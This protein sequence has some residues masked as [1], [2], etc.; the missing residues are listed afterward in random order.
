MLLILGSSS[1]GYEGTPQQP[2]DVSTR[3]GDE[4]QGVTGQQGIPGS[5]RGT[6]QPPRWT[7]QPVLGSQ[8]TTKSC[9]LLQ[10]DQ[11][12]R[13]TLATPATTPRIWCEAEN[14]AFIFRMPPAMALTFPHTLSRSPRSRSD[15]A[16]TSQPTHGSPG[17]LCTVTFKALMTI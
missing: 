15:A 12:T 4:H 17:Q 11:H 6:L 10:P 7:S 14:E 2:C 9:V 16:N 3:A 1:S 13:S 8:S 5:A